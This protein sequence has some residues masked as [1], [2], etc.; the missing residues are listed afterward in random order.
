MLAA[1]ESEKEAEAAAAVDGIVDKEKI[2][3]GEVV[4]KSTGHTYQF[5][6]M[7]SIGFPRAEIKKF[8]NFP[9]FL[10]SRPNTTSL[11][12][13]LV[14]QQ[15][16]DASWRSQVLRESLPYF[17]KLPGIVHAWVLPVEE[18]EQKD[19]AAGYTESIIDNSE[20]GISAFEYHNV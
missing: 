17:K 20:P 10:T 13:Q 18:A 5:Q 8:A 11:N 19:S 16:L 14:P 4:A 6:I 2:R 9:R 7:E 1:E 3:K 15:P 12:I